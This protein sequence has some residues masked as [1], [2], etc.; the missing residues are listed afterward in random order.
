MLRV[1]I[2]KMAP[3]FCHELVEKVT[4][5]DHCRSDGTSFVSSRKACLAE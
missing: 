3:V 5:S 4:F 2:F 1:I